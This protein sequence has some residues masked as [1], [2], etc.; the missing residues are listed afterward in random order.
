MHWQ[1]FR[2]LLTCINQDNLEKPDHPAVHDVNRKMQQIIIYSDFVLFVEAIYLPAPV[3]A[4]WTSFKSLAWATVHV[5]TASSPNL[6]ECT[7][8]TVTFKCKWFLSIRVVTLFSQIDPGGLT[9]LVLM[10]TELLMAAVIWSAG[11][12]TKSPRPTPVLVP[13]ALYSH[14]HS[15]YLNTCSVMNGKQQERNSQMNHPQWRHPSYGSCREMDPGS[16][17]AI[18]QSLLEFRVTMY[19]TVMYTK[20]MYRV[21]K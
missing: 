5:Y 3:S 8:K 21:T 10:E 19:S 20:Y 12:E 7:G 6:I 18:E 13:F 14:S 1:H 11:S 16:H 4:L 15:T 2:F 17:D 9:S